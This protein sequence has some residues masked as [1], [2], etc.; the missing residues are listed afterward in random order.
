MPNTL[1]NRE[2]K[3]KVTFRIGEN[4]AEIYFVL[5]KKEHPRFIV[6]AILR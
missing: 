5:K 3:M 6:K 4:E 2:E 1:F